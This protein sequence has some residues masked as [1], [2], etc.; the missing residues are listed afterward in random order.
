MNDHER[1]PIDSPEFKEWLK[2]KSQSHMDDILGN[3]HESSDFE[4][5]G[6]T[7]GDG[8]CLD[9]SDAELFPDELD[10]CTPEERRKGLKLCKGKGHKRA[11]DER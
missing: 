5:G 7:F 3:E 2:Q 9:K 6:A 8:D 11:D 10:E 1:P 4:T